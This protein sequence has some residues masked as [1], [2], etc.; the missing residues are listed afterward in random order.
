LGFRVAGPA[1]V[2]TGLVLEHRRLAARAVHQIGHG[3]AVQIEL[4]TK[5]EAKLIA[6]NHA[7]VSSALF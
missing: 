5:I 4:D 6:V 3:V 1:A 7:S 2:V